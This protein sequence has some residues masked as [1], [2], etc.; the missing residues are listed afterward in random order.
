MYFDVSIII[1]NYKT[2]QLVIDCVQSIIEKTKDINYE[3]IV[4]DNDSKDNSKVIIER[5]LGDKIV[6]IES[7]ENLGFGKG[8]NLGVKYA[9][10]KYLFFLNSDT[11]LINNAIK[12]LYDF[13][14]SHKEIGIVGGNLYTIDL[15]PS[16][17]FSMSFDQIEDYKN[18]SRWLSIL[19]TKILRHKQ[20]KNMTFNDSNNP[21]KVGY[22]FG[23]DMMIK[24]SL[25]DSIGGFDSDF[26]MYYEEED[27]SY[28]IVESGKEIWSIPDAKIIHLDGASSKTNNEFNPK[29]FKMRLHGGFIYFKKRLGYDGVEK[30]YKYRKRLFV[31]DRLIAKLLHRTNT[32]KIRNEH[33]RCL[34][35]VYQNV[36]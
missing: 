31:R 2:P 21:L 32:V 28:R 17:S 14:I 18:D 10:G 11:I 24:K 22:V 7:N 30:Y 16:P 23:T 35:E 29:H 8:N 9:Q 15:N 26:F 20:K 3:I 13:L 6:F 1:I 36:K 4:V 27:L 12:I 19:K 5:E 25:F 34:E 33:I